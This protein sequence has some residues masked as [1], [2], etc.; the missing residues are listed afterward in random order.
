ML[1]SRLLFAIA[2][3]AAAGF[4][5]SR[6]SWLMQNYRFTGPPRPGTAPPPTSAV[7][8]LKEIQNATLSIMRKADFWGDWEAALAA[9]A[10][11]TA[12]AQLIGALTGELR[13]PQPPQPVRPNPAPASYLIALRD[14]SVHPATAV[15]TDHFMLHY[16]TPEGVHE[17]VRPDL[18]DWSRTS[19]ESAGVGD[20]REVP[21]RLAQKPLPH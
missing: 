8:Q 12:T 21:E 2:L 4:A 1:Y 5:Q 7:N 3:T 6:D 13:P 15:W 11:A 19:L 20:S 9:A 10:Q 18:V 17:Q 16:T 14:G